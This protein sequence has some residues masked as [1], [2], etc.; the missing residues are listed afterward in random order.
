MLGILYAL[1]WSYEGETNWNMT[2]FECR[3]T[4]HKWKKDQVKIILL[5]YGLFLPS[6][7]F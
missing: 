3:I 6:K 4:I 2:F 5:N 1:F 7:A